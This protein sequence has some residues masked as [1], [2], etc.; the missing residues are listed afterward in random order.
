MKRFFII[1]LVV[2]CH[3]VGAVGAEDVAAI[4]RRLDAD[5]LAEREAA[6]DELIRRGNE[7]EDVLPTE[8]TLDEHPEFSEEAIHRLKN[9]YQELR[10]RT[11]RESLKKIEFQFVKAEW[12]ENDR[13]WVTLRVDWPKDVFPIRLAFPMNTIRGRDEDNRLLMPLIRN[14]TF[15][16]P[17]GKTR[18]SGELVF[19]MQG[20]LPRSLRGDCLVLLA[21]GE[22]TFEFRRFFADSPAAKLERTIRKGQ[23]T[24]SV[25]SVRFL[26]VEDSLKSSRLTILFRVRFDQAFAALDSHRTWIYENEVLLRLRSGGQVEPKSVTPVEQSGNDIVLAAT[27]ELPKEDEIVALLYT[28]PTV[29]IEETLQWNRAHPRRD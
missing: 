16:I 2:C 27:F 29:I 17:L 24:V 10:I 8:E 25:E 19:A 22:K 14:G 20:G 18:F 12:D 3:T 26:P 9:V 21:I 6:E 28:T 15:E 5:R 23:T 13:S 7:I 11:I 4:L 1:V